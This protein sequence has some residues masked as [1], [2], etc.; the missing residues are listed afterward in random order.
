MLATGPARHGLR[1]GT[2]GQSGLKRNLPSGQLKPR[3]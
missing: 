2:F 1:N 3:M